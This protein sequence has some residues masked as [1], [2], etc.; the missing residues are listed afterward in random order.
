MRKV[1][2]QLVRL[3]DEIYYYYS[4]WRN[5]DDENGDA[6]LN[7]RKV[8]F[9]Q[10][11]NSKID[12]D[13]IVENFDK[14]IDKIREAGTIVFMGRE[15]EW[16]EIRQSIHEALKTMIRR[17]KESRSIRLTQLL[18]VV[19]NIL[20]DMEGYVK[21]T[22]NNWTVSVSHVLKLIVFKIDSIDNN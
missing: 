6:V 2:T 10:F 3:F 1:I 4:I 5:S 7:P 17:T 19:L 15:D 21:I 14:T 16:V 9:F 13:R 20:D 12:W 18:S 8:N 22:K 11:L